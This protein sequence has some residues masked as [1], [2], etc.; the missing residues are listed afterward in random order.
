LAF[1]LRPIHFLSN[2]YKFSIIFAPLEIGK[3]QH[4]FEVLK[5]MEF[6]NLF[7]HIYNW[8][9][10]LKKKLHKVLGFIRRNFKYPRERYQDIHVTCYI[11]WASFKVIQQFWP[12]KEHIVNVILCLHYIP[13]WGLLLIISLLLK[14]KKIYLWMSYV[15]CN[16]SSY[17]PCD[18][19]LE[20]NICVS[21]VMLFFM[22]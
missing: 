5:F 20:K 13:N 14:S 17:T 12:Y 10:C 8:I 18:K 21:I 9:Q 11:Q 3:F 6:H 19:Y 1:L 7:V 22:R 15:A 4:D 16:V 2:V